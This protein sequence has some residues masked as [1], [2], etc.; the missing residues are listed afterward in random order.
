MVSVIGCVVG[1]FVVDGRFGKISKMENVKNEAVLKNFVGKF[2]GVDKIS[3][4]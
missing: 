4:V 2:W 3:R 1:S